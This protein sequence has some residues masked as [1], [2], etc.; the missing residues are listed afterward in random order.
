VSNLAIRVALTN[1]LDAITPV[2]L[3]N[4]ENENFNN[5][6][7]IPYQVVNLLPADTIDLEMSKTMVI[8]SGIFHVL[9]CYPLSQGVGFVNQRV[10]L[11]EAAFRRGT[12]F[13]NSGYTVTISGTPA[14]GQGRVGL[15]HYELP[16]RIRYYANTTPL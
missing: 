3:T 2:L 16:V 12:S 5:N 4:Y 8:K 9:V 1:A 11:L 13:S 7:T 10:L 6:A 15:T 14:V